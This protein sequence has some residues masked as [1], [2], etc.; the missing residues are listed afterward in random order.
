[1][2]SAEAVK[3]T[4]VMI[5]EAV[6]NANEGVS[7]NEESLKNLQEMNERIHRVG[8]MMAEIASASDQQRQDIEKISSSVGVMT[9]VT[10]QNAANSEQ[11]VGAAEQLSTQADEMLGMVGAF[12][13][14]R[15]GSGER[16]S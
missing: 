6:K 2:R 1:M 10:E 16:R 8:A 11:S 12:K 9:G 14:N 7:L 15:N 13:L 3:D 4:A 5:E